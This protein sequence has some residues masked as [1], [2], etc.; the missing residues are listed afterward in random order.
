MTKPRRALVS[1][2][3]AALLLLAPGAASALDYG[4]I[5]AQTAQAGERGADFSTDSLEYTL[6]AAPWLFVGLGDRVELYVSGGLRVDRIVDEWIFAPELYRFQAAFQVF[7][8]LRI[9][10]GRFQYRDSLDGLIAA[11]LFDGL[12]LS[13]DLPGGRLSAGGYY[14]GF[15]YKKTADIVMNAADAA[16]YAGAVEYES[17]RTFAD[18]YFA[19]R[20]ALASLGWDMAD[21]LGG[22]F[23]LEALGQIDLT[24]RDSLLHTGYL[25]IRYARPLGNLVRFDLGGTASVLQEG[26]PM[27]L[28]FSFAGS[29]A[30][31]W[32]LPTPF[33]DELRVSFRGSSGEFTDTF[34]AFHPVSTATVGEVLRAPLSSLML[35]DI[36]YTLRILRVLSLGLQGACILRTDSR[37]Y[38]DPAGELLNT[39]SS[40]L[41]GEEAYARLSWTPL[42]DLSFTLGGGVF[43]P[44]WGGAY[45]DQAR[46]RWRIS[47]GSLF[48]F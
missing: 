46:I 2:C 20:R 12:S 6:Q 8:Q 11:G 16:L 47:L 28:E 31:G 4:L 41:L 30:L 26:V 18:S 21:L 29:A 5:F 44:N 45:V 9:G 25:M 10:L 37:S 15:Q 42:S 34:T 48:S 24:G 17:P 43:F 40:P 1:C 7:P 39:S 32:L 14:A 3:A 33:P 19:P 38:Q 36:T 35:A 23:S 22:A 27:A 13:L